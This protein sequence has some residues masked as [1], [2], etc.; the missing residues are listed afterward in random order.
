MLATLNEAD[1]REI[2]VASL[3]NRKQLLAAIAA[4]GGSTEGGAGDARRPAVAAAQPVRRQLT[5]LFCDLVCL[6]AHAARPTCAALWTRSPGCRTRRRGGGE[7]LSC[8]SRSGP[9]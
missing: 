1:L 2:G 4:L 7:S 8:R 6:T 3:G 5:V 9:R